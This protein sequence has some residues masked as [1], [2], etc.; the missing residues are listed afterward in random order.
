M[1]QLISRAPNGP[2]D[3]AEPWPGGLASILVAVD[4][5]PG[6]DQAL[7]T[8]VE[9]VASNGRLTL[10]SSVPR[11]HWL[12]SVAVAFGAPML[13]DFA[14]GYGSSPI[15]PADGPESPV[16]LYWRSVLDTA[17]A[18]VPGSIRV[19]TVLDRGPLDLT[20]S[21]AARGSGY[22]LVIV[23]MHRRGRRATRLRAGTWA[24]LAARC[25]TSLLIALAPA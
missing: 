19:D 5:S 14:E 25:R 8:A 11:P 13:P 18:S 21:R 6:S 1:T 7:R 15:R 4:G 20:V 23:G 12:L 22:D 9:L 10:V 2:A 17:A 3:L 24:R 16:V